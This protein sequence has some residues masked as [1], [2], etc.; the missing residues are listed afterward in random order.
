KGA[1]AIRS[2]GANSAR[3]A[4]PAACQSAGRAVAARCR[5]PATVSQP[6]TSNTTA[7]SPTASP[8]WYFSA[9]TARHSISGKEPV[10]LARR[11]EIL[12]G[13]QALK[14]RSVLRI[15]EEGAEVAQV[16]FAFCRDVA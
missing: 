4:C 6:A 15:E 3:T 11:F 5:S 10:L 2:P 13:V 7:R 12:A 9:C 16:G 8:R 1:M 14:E